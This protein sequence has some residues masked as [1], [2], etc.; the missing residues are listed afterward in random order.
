[1][2]GMAIFQRSEIWWYEFPLR[3][4]ELENRARVHP[5][6]SPEP[7]NETESGSSKQGTP[8]DGLTQ[9]YIHETV[10]HMTE[11]VRGEVSTQAIEIFGHALSRH[12]TEHTSLS[13]H[14]TWSVILMSR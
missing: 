10:N 12:L 11:Y 9:Q 4:D 7:Q 3:A 8:Y 1:M 14:F 2:V 13:S 5:K 6:H